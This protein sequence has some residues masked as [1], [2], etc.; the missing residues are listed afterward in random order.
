MQLR[1]SP[2][3]RR[4][5]NQRILSSFYLRL[6]R[7]VYESARKPSSEVAPITVADREFLDG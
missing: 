7:Q 6:K 1:R 4:W 5:K 2:V 3:L